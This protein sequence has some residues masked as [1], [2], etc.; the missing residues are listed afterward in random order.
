MNDDDNQ[1]LG[2]LIFALANGDI[3]ALSDIYL[4]TSKILYAVGNIYFSQ[5][6]DI[7]DAIHNLLMVLCH[8]AK[9]FKSNENACAW[10]VRLFK[11]SIINQLR[12]RKRERDY[13]IVK[14][15]KNK[16][17]AAGALCLENYIFIG[18]I[19]GRLNEYERD[20]IIYRYWCNCSIKEIADIFRLPK[21][22]MES[23]LCKL[24]DKIKKF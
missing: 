2:E 24:E 6:A 16:S 5:T 19:F 8:K 11:H 7:E 22:T 23:Q 15:E 13:F 10:I 17:R 4:L 14:N 21:S 20:L 1:R 18:E 9:K 3:E 12:R